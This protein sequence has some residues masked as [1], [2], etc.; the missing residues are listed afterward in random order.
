MTPAPD[1]VYGPTQDAVSVEN[2]L[3]MILDKS[4]F[5]GYDAELYF[6]ACELFV[7]NKALMCN[8]VHKTVL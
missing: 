8:C 5:L 1:A 4:C 3:P 6:E 7:H 2:G